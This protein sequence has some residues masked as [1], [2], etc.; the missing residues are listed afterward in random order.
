MTATIIDGKAL[1][2][3]LRARIAA[4]TAEL[5]ADHGIVPG[6]AAVLVGEDPASQVYVNMKHRACEAA[7]MLSRQVQLP[8]ETP[9]DE[10]MSVVDELNADDAIDGIL[11]QLPLPDPLDP[12]EVQERVDPDKDVDALHPVTGGRLLRGDPTFVPAT[13]YGVLELLRSA[14]VD[15]RGARVVIVG[16]SNLVGRPLSVLLSLKGIDAIVTVAHSRTRDLAAVCREGDVLVA[17]VGVAGLVTAEH[18][19]PGAVV[20]D[21]GT[22][23][24]DDGKLVG[25]VA[26]DEVAEVAGA[27]T[28]VPGGVGPMTVTMLLQ[29]TLEAARARHGLPRRP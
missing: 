11:V 8:A 28:P 9:Q 1:A 26:F 12:D 14:D 10:L 13:P 15:L 27:I 24:T 2:E 4:E 29:N 20:I 19:K 16:R 3:R 7:G 22:N 6:L 18:V 5:K 17:A 21:V 25:D 23:R